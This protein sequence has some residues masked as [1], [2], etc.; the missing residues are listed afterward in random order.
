MLLRST[1]QQGGQERKLQ[2]AT[3]R[4]FEG[5]TATISIVHQVPYIAGAEVSGRPGAWLVDPIVHVLPYGLVVE[6]TV[7]PEVGGTHVVE[8]RFLRMAPDTPVRTMPWDFG[9]GT[10]IN[11]EL[12]VM[13]EVSRPFRASLAPGGSVSIPMPALPSDRTRT[14][15]T[16]TTL[17]LTLTDV[18]AADAPA[19]TPTK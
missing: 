1:A 13:H 7:R 8:G 14:A 3:V 19:P 2:S 18:R 10:P 17:T 6:A 9:V 16:S 15:T 4:V 5:Q 11:V 12:P